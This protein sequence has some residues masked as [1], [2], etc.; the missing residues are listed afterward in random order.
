MP[1]RNVVS[2]TAMIVGYSQS[3]FCEESLKLFYQM[4]NSG[5]KPNSFTFNSVLSTCANLDDLE[6]SN[7]IYGQIIKMGFESD[8]SVS[9]ALVNLNVKLGSIDRARQLFDNM[10]ERDIYSWTTMVAGYAQSGRLEDARELFDKMPERNV[11]PWSAM[12][13]G[14]S[15]N[16]DCE[17]ALNLFLQMQQAGVKPNE[18]TLSSVLSACAGL[19]A[20]EA[21]KQVHTYIIK[22][23]LELD[24]FVGSA[25]VDMYAKSGSMECANAAFSTSPETNVVLWNSM[26]AGHAQNGQVEDALE[27]FCKMP[28]RNL[29]SWNAMIAA[30]SQNEQSQRALDLFSQMQLDG[31]TPD[32][33]T[34]TSVL[35]ACANIAAMEQGKQAHAKVIE[36]RLVSDVF[37]GRAL[38]DMYAKCGSIEDARH[39]FDKM[40]VRNVVSWT[41]MILGYA[42]HGHGKTAL[43]LFD[44]MQQAGMKPNHIT[45]V[46]VLSGCSH[47][48]LVEDGWHHFSSMNRDYCLTPREEHYTC[49][50]DLLCRAGR[51]DEA[52]NFIKKMPFEPNS[53]VWLS[54]LSACKIYVNVELGQHAAQRLFEL[55]AENPSTYVMLSNIYAAAG[56]WEDVAK[57]RELMKDRRIQKRPGCSW[58]EVKGKVHTF[59][60]EDNL[61]PKREEIYKMLDTLTV[62]MKEA[63]YVPDTNHVLHD[64]EE[65]LKEIFLSHHS[66][67]LA[68]AFGLISTPL[69]TP[70]RIIKNLRVCGDCHIAIKFISKI[71]ERQIVVRDATRFHHF[72]DGFCSCG[73]YW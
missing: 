5:T 20:L 42:L 35:S 1:E 30:Y 43:L 73:D 38:V 12:I 63:G 61:H 66:E 64:V 56:R 29:V 69:G 3:G 36:Q 31:W 57:V 62:Q 32:Q 21:G 7:H 49:M 26:I 18:S 40:P 33:C 2:W 28:E 9:N 17:D 67:K 23:G 6:Q 52:E 50:V 47:S 24:V 55:E 22:R 70:I 16:D 60:V 4:Q 71:V 37:M 11:V 10:P 44:E 65:E 25:L 39:V 15:Q 46:G 68:I 58:M 54:L 19:A 45:F 14:Y 27:I 72:K 59:L 13:S 8:V 41:V 53:V 51:L 48:G 34:F